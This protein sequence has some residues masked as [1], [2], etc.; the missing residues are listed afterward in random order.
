[1][2]AHASAVCTLRGY[3]TIDLIVTLYIL[4]RIHINLEL[5]FYA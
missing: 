2:H 4:H 5:M 1:M 3:L